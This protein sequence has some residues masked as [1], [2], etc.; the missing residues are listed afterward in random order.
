MDLAISRDLVDSTKNM[1]GNA[2]YPE[3]PLEFLSFSSSLA[4]NDV[5]RWPGFR[6]DAP[7]SVLEDFHAG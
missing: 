5:C 1:P 2:V 3:R 4:Q 6:L 7:M